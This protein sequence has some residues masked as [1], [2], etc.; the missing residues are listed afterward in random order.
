MYSS[1]PTDLRVPVNLLR[2]VGGAQKPLLLPVN[3]ASAFEF[4]SRFVMLLA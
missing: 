4:E 1:F 3:S 2:S